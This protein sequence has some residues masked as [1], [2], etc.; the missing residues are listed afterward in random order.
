[1]T[2][3]NP[4]HYDTPNSDTTFYEFDLVRQLVK[5]TDPLGNS[6]ESFYD[7]NGNETW[8][9]NKRG[10]VTTRTYDAHNRLALFH[11]RDR[12]WCID[13]YCSCRIWSSYGLSQEVHIQEIGQRTGKHQERR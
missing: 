7:P 1:M 9:K 8:T 12:G 6:I 10:S 11:R 4:I 5:E 13:I 3:G 2:I